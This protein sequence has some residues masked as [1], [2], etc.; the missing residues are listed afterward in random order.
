MN[1][2]DETIIKLNNTKP[3]ITVIG[4][5]AAVAAGVWLVRSHLTG[6]QTPGDHGAIV[7]FFVFISAL[8]GLY[9]VL[10][11]KKLLNRKPGLILSPA[12]LFDNSGSVAS[13]GLIP[14]SDIEGFAAYKAQRQTFLIIRMTY[15]E[16]YIEGGSILKRFFYKMNFRTCGSPIII[17][18]NSLQIDFNQLAYLC[19]QYL[20]KYGKT[21]SE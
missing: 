4:A 18:S 19:T 16:R 12:G 8:F 1:N 11:A 10:A 6:S 15:P 5:I 17:V 9:G 20:Q 3:M 7:Y 13:A 14:W 21:A 2:P